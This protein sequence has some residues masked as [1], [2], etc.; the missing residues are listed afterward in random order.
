MDKVFY[1]QSSAA[2]LGW[3]PEWFG[4]DQNDEE[5]VD[6]I[7]AWQKK[8]G[9][10][11]DGMCGPSTYRRIWTEREKDI[12]SKVIHH[13]G[14]HN[15][16]HPSAGKLIGHNGHFY[17]I[18]WPVVLWDSPNAL[19]SDYGT[20]YDY[21]GKE[22]RKPTFFVNHWMF[23]Y[24]QSPA[25]RSSTREVFQFISVLIMMEPSISCWIHNTALGMLVA[26]SGI[27]SL[28]VLR[29]LMLSI[30]NTKNTM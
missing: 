20:F 26:K 17:D 8:N 9:I 29:S 4:A 1:N 30:R 13:I 2:K 10:G 12:S 21:S 6:A 24:H 22:D 28:S 11:A 23:V 18:D 27:T 16:D 19:A 3:E 25:Q 5:C 14:P 15:G 7:A